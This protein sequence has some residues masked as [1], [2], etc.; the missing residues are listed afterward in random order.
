[1]I[2]SWARC[3]ESAY[4]S[5]TLHIKPD[6]WSLEELDVGVHVVIVNH[7]R[8]QDR[9][10]QQLLGFCI[11]FQADLIVIDEIHK[12]K[13][14]TTETSSQR[15]KLMNEFIRISINLNPD[16]RVLGLS[17]TPVIN[18]L[19]EGRS[20]IELICQEPFE[21]IGEKVD[22]TSCMNLYQHFVVR[23]IRMNPGKMPR[24]EIRLHDV[25]A[26]QLLPQIVRATKR[27]SFHDIEQLLVPPK[28]N[29]LSGMLQR[30][31]K[32]VIFITYIKNTLEPLCNWLNANQ[33]SFSVFTGDDKDAQEEGFRDSL[34]EF[35]RGSSEV[36]VATI[37]CAGTGIDGLQ[38]VCN[39]AIFFQLPWTSTEFEQA[40]GRLD[41]D[42]TDFDSVAI[43]IP[44][45][46]I[47][48]PDGQRWS[49]CRSK[50][51]RIE[52]KRD[53]A[54]AAV[55][56]EIPDAA[57][58]ITPSEASKYWLNWLERLNADPG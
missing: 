13:R 55:D 30:G 43:H 40:I 34:D 21:D 50:L 35:I 47:A 1:V 51:D 14:R 4:P 20:L 27:G 10:A 49:W 12:S 37:Q 48:L 18:N 33:F 16:L 53:I 9:L 32:T 41:R 57:T 2:D 42:G 8:F 45:T 17:A 29:S 46:D 31:S 5:A 38:S 19:Y 15:R 39:R 11:G 28:I 6:S 23:G 54:K 7:E 3:F 24:T 56:G 25:D 36:L 26:T 44:I 52:S 58:L 22:L